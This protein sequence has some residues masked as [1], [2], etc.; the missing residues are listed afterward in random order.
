MTEE[1]QQ[2]QG[3]G[4]VSAADAA[5]K[6]EGQHQTRRR[7]GNTPNRTVA[8]AL[9]AERIRP[10]TPG[11]GYCCRCPA[12][13]LRGRDHLP[14]DAVIRSGKPAARDA[15]RAFLTGRRAG[16]RISPATTLAGGRLSPAAGIA[17]PIDGPCR[18]VNPVNAL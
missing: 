18:P 3:T 8:P 9:K 10:S 13:H 16:V 4:E 7:C 5:P 1:V 2:D 14:A 15:V 12:R 17:G 6:R 11:P